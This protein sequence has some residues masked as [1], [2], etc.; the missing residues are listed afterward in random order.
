MAEKITS[1][2]KIIFWILLVIFLWILAVHFAKTEEILRVLSSG[3][4]YWIALAL[5]MQ[6][7]LYPFYAYYAKYVLGM[8]QVNLGFKNIL[9]IYLASKF[10]DVAFPI[11]T[12][13]K[14][15]V[16]VRNGKK[17]NYSSFDTAVG[18][19][20]V[21]FFELVAFTIIALT[22]LLV[23]FIT[24]QSQSYLLIPIFALVFIVLVAIALLTR[25]II[26]KRKIGP[27][28]M[29]LILWI[30]R[31][32]HLKQANQENIE[33]A[34]R[35]I[36]DDLSNA[37]KNI[38]KALGLAFL[39][40]LINLLTLTFI[41]LAF[42]GNFNF[43]AILATYVGGILFTIISITP[44]GVG[45]AETIM[46]TTMRAY[47]IDFSTATVITLAFRGLLYLL[48]MFIGFYFFSHLE[49]KRQVN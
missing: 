19:S 10:T 42:A 46:I 26:A 12:V 34:F 47:G 20:L 3:K 48:P 2:K 31:L 44:Q 33:L 8:F 22:S 30:A 29:K 17:L 14:V 43:F 6:F 9:Y 18:T 11:S 41:F 28:F 49:L 15:A 38:W 25:T 35:K 7:F 23:L 5:L 16:F 21:L 37:K 1:S 24:H 39:V 4:W 13:G 32:F 40:H 27:T 45:V 36:G